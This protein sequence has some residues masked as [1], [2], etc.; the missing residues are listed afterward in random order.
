MFTYNVPILCSTKYFFDETKKK[1]EK[2]VRY[3]KPIY[4]AIF[5]K[6]KL[7]KLNVGKD[8]E[9]VCPRFRK[10]NARDFFIVVF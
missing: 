6:M 10:L 5:N 7:M 9:L 3:K 4:T 1:C 8:W 2:R